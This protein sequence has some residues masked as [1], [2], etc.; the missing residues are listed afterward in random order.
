[1][2]LVGVSC[3]AHD[4]GLAVLR[5]GHIVFASHSE[6]Y[7]RK[8]NDPLLNGA[9]ID[10]ALRYADDIEGIV[11]YEHPLLKRLRQ[12]SAR[13]W[14]GALTV[15]PKRYLQQFSAL[16]GK[17]VHFVSHHMSHAAGAYFTS[18]FADAAVVVVD[19]I[20]EWDTLTVWHARGRRLRKVHSVRYPH[21]LGLFYS[22]LTQRAGLKP[23]EEEYILMGMA[24][25]GTPRHRELLETE[26][27]DARKP[28][29]FALRRS[30]HRGLGPRWHPE[31]TRAPDLASSAQAVLE[32]FL[33]GLFRWVARTVPS[34]NL[35]YTGGV[36]LN[37]LFNGRLAGMGLFDDIWIPP[38]PGDAG[39]A[40]GALAAHTRDHLPW[41]G[42]YLGHDIRRETDPDRIVDALLGGT[43]AGLANGRAEYGPRA[44]GNRSLLAD[45]RDPA[46]KDRVNAV[47]K[48][49]RYRPFAPVVLA[50]Y[51]DKL[52]EMPVA[53]APYMQYVVACREPGTYPAVCHVD[54]TSRV[55]TLRRDQN[56]LLHEV[57]SRFHRR[58]GCPMLL[59]TSLNIRGQPLVNTWQDAQ[60]FARKYQVPVF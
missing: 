34:R 36:A 30:L 5:D 37:C 55:Q 13:N 2:A 32:S 53:E 25:Y 59:N 18:P 45:P 48:R 58:T 4:A 22:A 19:A 16:R 40:V 33:T 47:K 20:G 51:A 11:Y 14:S 54:G 46:A 44:L 31:L 42:P 8:K 3:L 57:I 38:N 12:L 15:S 17:P 35:V 43:V 7:S 29:E 21:S 27:L 49:Q 1:M 9:L 39:S 28:P 50:E 23:N 26:L 60:D 52:F 10:D 56:P 6:R 41:E 24:G